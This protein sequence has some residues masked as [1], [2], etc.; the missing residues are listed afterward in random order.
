M[1]SRNI[2]ARKSGPLLERAAH[3]LKG[4]CSNFGAERMRAACQDLESIA[5]DGGLEKA[6]DALVAIE[7]EFGYV[8]H[9]L[10]RERALSPA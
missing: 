10:E 8:R 9:A 1:S 5:R 3:S 2:L 7:Q 6:A 4:S